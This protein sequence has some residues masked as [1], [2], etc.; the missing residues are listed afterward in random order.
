MYITK[1][2]SLGQVISRIGLI[3][4]TVFLIVLYLS[5][6]SIDNSVLSAIIL[7]ISIFDFAV[8]LYN[9]TIYNSGLLMIFFAYTILVHNGFVIAFL[10]D[11]SYETFQSVTS[12][13]FRLNSY[14][15]S[16]IIIS[17]IIIASFVLIMEIKTKKINSYWYLKRECKKES[18]EGGNKCADV[19]GI[20]LL[21]LGFLYIA[22]FIFSHGLFLA[23][24]ITT[25]RSLENSTMFQYMVIIT[26]LSI[27]L[28]FSTGTK[29]GIKIAFGVYFL[30]TILQFSIG[31]RGEVLYAA[32]VCFALYSIRYKTIKTKHV[33][34]A[35]V[36]AAIIIPFVRVMRNLE[37]SMYT[38]NPIASFLDVLAEEGIEISP[39]TYIVEYSQKNGHVWGMTY[40]ADFID[41]FSRRLGFVNS[42]TDEKY[43]IKSIMPYDG[44]GFTLIAELYY[45]FGLCISTILFSGIGFWLKFLDAKFTN[46]QVSDLQRIGCSLLLVELINLTR[47]DASTLPLYLFFI[48][49][50]MIAYAVLRNLVDQRMRSQ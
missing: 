15:P 31:N 34:I 18:I 11:K 48:A 12:M 41:F 43:I 6:D 26:S 20:S 49:I 7:I 35:V 8:L 24:Y 30:I 33:I 10:F 17:N 23:G 25:L 45:N 13:A 46:F 27:A 3:S 29:K 39:F 50:F 1:S 44:M 14:Y 28:V 40:I 5:G 37:I 38:L 21:V 9:P 32:V 19:M 4:L 36:I 42:L 2:K 22:F 47:N 16:A